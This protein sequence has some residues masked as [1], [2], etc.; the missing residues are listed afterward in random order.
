M[1]DFGFGCL[2]VGSW[3]IELS[4]V[5]EFCSF[6]HLCPNVNYKASEPSLTV[7]MFCCVSVLFQFV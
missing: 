5:N 1:F 2:V 3:A 6:L 4:F 7:M